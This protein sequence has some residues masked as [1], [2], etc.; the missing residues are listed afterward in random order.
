MKLPWQFE[1]FLSGLS[2]GTAYKLHCFGWV[3]AGLLWMSWAIHDRKQAKAVI[4]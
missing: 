2:F 1:A 4:A 3:I